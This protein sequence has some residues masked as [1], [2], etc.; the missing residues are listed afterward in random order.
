MG[1][2]WPAEKIEQVGTKTVYLWTITE[3][4]KRKAASIPDP[5]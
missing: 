1:P 4:E 2:E 3:A 5:E